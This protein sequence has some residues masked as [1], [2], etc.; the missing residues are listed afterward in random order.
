[1]LWTYYC[2]TGMNAAEILT[3]CVNS[4]DLVHSPPQNICIRNT[5]VNC[6]SLK[7]ENV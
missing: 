5:V 3:D 1:M 6:A 4:N 2:K 7:T